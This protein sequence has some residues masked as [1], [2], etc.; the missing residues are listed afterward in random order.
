MPGAERDGEND[1]RELNVVFVAVEFVAV[2]AT[3]R[4]KGQQ[5]TKQNSA[6]GS[7]SVALLL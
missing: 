4:T 5:Q 2:T 1:L 6:A 7:F 3:C